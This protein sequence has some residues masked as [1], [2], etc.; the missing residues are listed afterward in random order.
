[1]RYKPNILDI[2]FGGPFVNALFAAG[3][4]KKMR[5]RPPGG[6]APLLYI[7]CSSVRPILLSCFVIGWKESA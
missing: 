4:G 2:D 5:W 6:A 7:M 3:Y 1:L